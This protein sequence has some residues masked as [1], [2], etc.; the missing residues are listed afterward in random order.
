MFLPEPTLVVGLI[1]RTQSDSP[2]NP[3]QRYRLT[4]YDRGIIAS[5]PTILCGFPVFAGWRRSSAFIGR[6]YFFQ[7]AYLRR[8]S[9]GA[10]ALPYSGGKRH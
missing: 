7:V 6:R 8:S 4:E 2:R 3:T 10:D 1:E 5:G 9:S